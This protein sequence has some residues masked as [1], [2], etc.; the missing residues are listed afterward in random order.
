MKSKIFI[1]SILIITI[2]GCNSDKKHL[3]EPNKNAFLIEPFFSNTEQIPFI[4]YDESRNI[5]TD[6]LSANFSE[7]QKKHKCISLSDLDAAVY[8]FV[9]RDGSLAWEPV[10]QYVFTSGGKE[11]YYDND[12][13]DDRSL[14]LLDN[15]SDSILLKILIVPY[16]NKNPAKF[17]IKKIKVDRNLRELYDKLKFAFPRG[18]LGKKVQ[19]ILAY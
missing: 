7:S 17:I 2:T 5:N 18:L 19:V 14:I 16:E 6:E 1:I 9:W 4:I 15:I 8:L 3:I 12:L 13:I 10:T 11:F